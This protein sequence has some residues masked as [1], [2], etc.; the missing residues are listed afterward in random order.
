[1]EKVDLGDVE[2]EIVKLVKKKPGLSVGGYM[3]LI[4]KEFKG[5]VSGKEVSEILG[6]LVK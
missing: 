4:M 6:K 3:G 2:S 5:K 1:M